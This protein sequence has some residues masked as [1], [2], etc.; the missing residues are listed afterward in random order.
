[1]GG[2]SVRSVELAAYVSTGDFALQLS[3]GTSHLVLLQ[4]TLRHPPDCAKNS[5]LVFLCC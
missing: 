5:R 4:A 2:A 1:M 3:D